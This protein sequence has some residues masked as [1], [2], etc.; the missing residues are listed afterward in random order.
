MIDYDRFFYAPRE[1]V[2]NQSNKFTL[3]DI[4]Q[5]QLNKRE[6]PKIVFTEL[7]QVNE[8]SLER[9]KKDLGGPDHGS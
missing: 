4:L 6:D 8:I 7:I 5:D 2:I 1:K 9:S 3:T